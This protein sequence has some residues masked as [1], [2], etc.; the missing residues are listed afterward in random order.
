MAL[1]QED[2]VGDLQGSNTK[3]QQHQKSASYRKCHWTPA[4]KL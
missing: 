1:E 2:R 4:E 3:R